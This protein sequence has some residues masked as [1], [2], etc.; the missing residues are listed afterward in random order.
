[1]QHIGVIIQTDTGE[2]KQLS[3]INFA[4]V[5]SAVFQIEDYKKAYPILSTIDPYANTCFVAS[6]LESMVAELND[7]KQTSTEDITGV[8]DQTLMFFSGVTPSTQICFIGD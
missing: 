7:L 5:M 2:L 6:Q 4:K 1:M 3:E 8:I